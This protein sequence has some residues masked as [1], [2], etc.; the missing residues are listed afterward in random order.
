MRWCDN[1]PMRLFNKKG[2]N[3]SGYGNPF[4]RNLIVVSNV[5]YI[6]YKK[7]NMAYS[8]QVEIIQQ[9]LHSST[10]SEELD[11]YV[12]PFIRCCE[13]VACEPDTNVISNCLHYLA[14]DIDKYNFSNI[15][16]LGSSVNR[17]LGISVKDY[18]DSVI[19]SNNKRKY[20]VNYS[21]LT[22]F[23]NDDLYKLFESK[24]VQWYNTINGLIVDNYKI[25]YL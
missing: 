2:Y 4:K 17:F 11:Y 15:M 6:S 22:K 21:P 13:R 10:G 18:L 12:V 19:I 24:L 20:Y 14:E 7:Q 5:D 8:S 3:L 23:V 16:L 25:V 9:V 1:C